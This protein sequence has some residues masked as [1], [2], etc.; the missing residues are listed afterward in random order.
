MSAEKVREDRLRRAAGRQGY[1]LSKSRTRDKRAL[2]YGRYQLVDQNS[3]EQYS[4]RSLDEIERWLTS[5]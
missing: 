2:T 3:R 1:T 4:S 5:R